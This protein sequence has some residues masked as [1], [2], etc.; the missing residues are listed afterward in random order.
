M[1]CLGQG[2]FTYKKKTEEEPTPIGPVLREV[3]FRSFLSFGAYA[4][5]CSDRRAAP[6]KGLSLEFSNSILRDFSPHTSSSVFVRCLAV[7]ESAVDRY[8]SVFFF[9]KL[10]RQ[11]ILVRRVSAFQIRV[12]EIANE[13]LLTE[14]DRSE[15]KEKRKGKNPVN[16]S[17]VKR[18]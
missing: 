11:R 1:T 18:V 5:S 12:L 14:S 7:R 17:P 8:F 4:A 9:F 16:R 2:E 15:R 10:E 13:K 6:A 3:T